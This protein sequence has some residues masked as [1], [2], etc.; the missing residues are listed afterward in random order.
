MT[1]A[2]KKKEVTAAAVAQRRLSKASPS[3][4]KNKEEAGAT[5]RASPAAHHLDE[6][7][8]LPVPLAVLTQLLEEDIHGSSSTPTGGPPPLYAAIETKQG[9]VYT[10]E[11]TGVDAYYNITLSGATVRRQR[12]CDVERHLIRDKYMALLSHID[13]MSTSLL[14]DEYI[15]R[16]DSPAHPRFVGAYVARSNNVVMIQFLNEPDQESMVSVRRPIEGEEDDAAMKPK[17]AQVSRLEAA[18]RST[19]SM[20]KKAL[21]KQRL[22]DR[23]AR[24]KRIAA[25]KIK[26]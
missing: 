3:L 13:H 18:F 1:S 19:A 22:A 8:R 5:A 7:S 21:Q 9:Y 15:E 24:R 10:G 14:P 4:E 12:R 2:R 17:F 26:K 6:P 20:I 11:V 25:E 23:Q 16:P